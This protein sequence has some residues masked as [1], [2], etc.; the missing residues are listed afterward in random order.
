VAKPAQHAG[1]QEHKAE[2]EARL[3]ERHA[4]QDRAALEQ[5]PTLQAYATYYRRFKKT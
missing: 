1:R 4:R 5:H 3:R 2:L